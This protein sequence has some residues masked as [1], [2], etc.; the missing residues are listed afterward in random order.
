MQRNTGYFPTESLEPSGNRLFSRSAL[1]EGDLFRG[2]LASHKKIWSLLRRQIGGFHRLHPQL[3]SELEEL[4][5]QKGLLEN[6]PQSE[7]VPKAP[8]FRGAAPSMPLACP[9]CEED[10]NTSYFDDILGLLNNREADEGRKLEQFVANELKPSFH[11]LLFG[12][13]DNMELADTDVYRRAGIDRRL[14][15]KIRSNPNYHPSKQTALALSLALH[16]SKEQTEEMLASAGHALSQSMVRDIIILFCIEH[17][18][19]DLHD[20]NEILAHFEQPVFGAVL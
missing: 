16:L 14:F 17:Q 20:V 1:N 5:R 13:I 4:L 6:D 19:Y 2:S 15:S 3:L 10:D 11:T 9:N 18:I 8:V 7:I 12:Y